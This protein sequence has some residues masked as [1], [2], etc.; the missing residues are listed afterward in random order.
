MATFL[1]RL[2]RASFRHRR[3]VLVGWLVLL[4]GLGGAALAFKGPTSSNFTMPGTESQQALDLLKRDFPAAIDDLVREA[5]ALPGVV[6]ALDP[7]VA[8]AV[9]PDGRYALVQV[10]FA[11]PLDE[12]TKAQRAAYERT[13]SAARAAGLRVEHGGEVTGGEPEIG[14]TE[15]LGVAVA[16]V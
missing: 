11:E 8:R 14:G 9:S 7:F 6:G 13:G 10:Q 15:S 12:I 1:Y 16:L 3:L 5:S 2:G 4:A